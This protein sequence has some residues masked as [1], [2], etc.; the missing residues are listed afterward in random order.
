MTS[1][2]F[3]ADNT[4]EPQVSLDDIGLTGPMFTTAEACVASLNYLILMGSMV[5][6]NKK[7]KKK[8]V[9]SN[10]TVC[11]QNRVEIENEIII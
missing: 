7:N 1:A 6:V 2:V 5:I 3:L 10:T 8:N 11:G 4:G 9:E